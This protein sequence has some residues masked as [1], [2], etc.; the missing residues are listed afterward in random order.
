MKVLYKNRAFRYVNYETEQQCYLADCRGWF[1]WR[2]PGGVLK[3]P[4]FQV[5]TND[6]LSTKCCSW[7]SGVF[8]L[9]YYRDKNLQISRH[10]N[11]TGKSSGQNE[12]NKCERCTE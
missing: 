6:Q 4:V 10:N 9:Q 1:I 2:V 7:G 12:L 8:F 3:L 11:L 5:N